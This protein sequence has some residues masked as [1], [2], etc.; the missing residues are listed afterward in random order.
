MEDPDGT[1]SSRVTTYE[2]R[3]VMPEEAFV[4]IRQMLGIPEG[5]NAAEDGSLRMATDVT[6]RRIML[7]GQAESVQQAGELLKLVD[8]PMQAFSSGGSI[9]QTPQLE[10]YP[11]Q[12][13]D[14]ESTLQ[15]LQ[16]L[17]A[18]EDVDLAL[19]PKTGS[20]I[21]LGLPSHHAT[22]RRPW[23]KCGRVGRRSK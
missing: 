7:T 4:V 2:L 20:L 15:V 1:Q 13:A 23:S 10:V 17:L 8:V 3:H 6:G 12:G 16:T 19:D 14:P 11:I 21:A 18:D 9:L 5:Q 22:I